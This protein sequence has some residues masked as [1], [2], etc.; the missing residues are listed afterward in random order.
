MLLHVTNFLLLGLQVHGDGTLLLCFDISSSSNNIWRNYCNMG[1]TF[2]LAYFLGNFELKDFAQ[3]DCE[4]IW[5]IWETWF[6][7]S[8]PC[9][10]LHLYSLQLIALLYLSIKCI[11]LTVPLTI[12]TIWEGLLGD[13]T[14]C[15]SSVLFHFYP[16]YCCVCSTYSTPVVPIQAFLLKTKPEFVL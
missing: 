4:L 12:R 8:D 7:L 9:K 15:L 1:C 11:C 14:L 10:I 6:F 13:F 16:H 3:I 5:M 2:F